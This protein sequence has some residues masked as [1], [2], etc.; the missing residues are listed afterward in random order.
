MPEIIDLY[1]ETLRDIHDKLVETLEEMGLEPGDVA[2]QVVEWIRR[3][4]NRRVLVPSWWGPVPAEPAGDEV[5]PGVNVESDPVRTMRGRE[6]RAAAW[7]I[8]AL[9]GMAHPCRVATALA[10]RVEEE[11]TG[12]YVY[13]PIAREVERAIR[14]AAIWRDFGGFGTIDA[15]VTKYNL[16]QSCVY[17]AFRK[18]QKEKSLREQPALPGL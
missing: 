2:V 5:L 6:L 1:P 18:L 16:C 3:N 14:D 9:R 7:E 4:W 10:S 8:V 15:L 12:E 13:V 17:D 11:W